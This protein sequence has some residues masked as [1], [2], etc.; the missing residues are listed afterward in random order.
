MRR[1]LVPVTDNQVH[2]GRNEVSG[3]RKGQTENRVGIKGIN[4]ESEEQV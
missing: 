2:Q 3:G 4:S 1:W